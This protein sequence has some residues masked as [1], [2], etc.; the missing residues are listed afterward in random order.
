MLT[1]SNIL[2]LNAISSGATGLLLVLLPNAIASIMGVNTTIP[3]IAVGVFLIA[4]AIFVFEVGLGKPVNRKAVK[5][6]IALDTTWVIVSAVAMVF[7]L[8]LLTWIGNAL[9]I[10]VA[11]WVAGMVYLQSKGLRETLKG[12]QV[13]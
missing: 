2:K 13:S 7:L 1:L 10:G 12:E 8:P 9:I 4:F 6:V 5:V 11:V 3:L